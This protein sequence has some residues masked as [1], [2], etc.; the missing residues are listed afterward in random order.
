MTSWY[1]PLLE[2]GWLPDPVIRAGIRAQ[3]RS[4]IAL[5]SAGGD[6]AVER[7][8]RELTELHG[9]GP[10]ARHT[11]D[12]NAQHYEVPPAFFEAVLGGHWKYSGGLWDGGDDSLDQSECRMLELYLERARIGDGQ[13]ILD[14][15]CGWGSFSL[16]AAR[17]FPGARFVAVSNSAPQVETI[18]ARARSLGLD[19]LEARRVDINDFHPE[20]RFDRVV[21]IEMFEHMH[22][23]R[24]LMRRI[25]HW[26]RPEGFL[27]VHHFAHRR[28]AYPY[29]AD[30]R[31][32]WMSRHFFTGGIMPSADWLARF[33]DHLE[34]VDSWNVDGTH[35]QRTCEA[36]L[37]N[38]TAHRNRV[39][40]ALAHGY[41]PDQTLRFW[42]MWRVFFMAC[43]ELFGYRGGGEW[44]VAHRL[45]QR[46]ATS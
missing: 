31:D 20:R 42:N 41:G 21:S 1:E 24:E 36:W 6:E 7:R 33:D 26:L 28:F 40:Q 11:D 3:L 16:F 43:A 8:I 30:N 18:R 4:R 14:L 45:L 15:G 46:R 34:V 2:R 29:V 35:Y 19:N 13:D 10:I 38:M 17:R 44:I 25:S 23:F 22:N 12:A 5:Q 9:E 39:L 32:E 27:F 37:Q